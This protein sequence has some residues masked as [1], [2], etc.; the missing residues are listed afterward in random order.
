MH[1]NTV[2]PERFREVLGHWP[3]GVVVVTAMTSQGPV[4]MSCN[5]F[6]SVSLRPPLVGFFP[7]VSSS[8][9]PAI[10]ATGRFCVNVL[11]RH[12]EHISRS[13]SRKD[14][15]RFAGITWSAGSA[16]PVIDDAVAWLACDLHDELPTGDHTL[17]LGLVT[18]L[19]AE[20]S[21]PPLIFHHGAYSQLPG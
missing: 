15:D 8:T 6:T 18:A 16:G 9:W 21:G 19:S 5:S 10:R 14:I 20:G 7:A 3:T 2:E 1:A 11:A 13:F 12:H 4:G 17:A